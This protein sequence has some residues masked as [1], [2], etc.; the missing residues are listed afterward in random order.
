MFLSGVSRPASRRTRCC[1]R[2]HGHRRQ[3]LLCWTLKGFSLLE[4]PALLPHR[5]PGAFQGPAGSGHHWKPAGGE[6]A[7]QGPEAGDCLGR[8]GLQAC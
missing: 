3:G 5:V 6:G 7:C 2:R 1:W 4:L 8:K